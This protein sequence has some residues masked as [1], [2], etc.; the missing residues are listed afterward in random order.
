MRL[1]LRKCIVNPTQLNTKLNSHLNQVFNCQSPIRHLSYSSCLF[2]R[3]NNLD[4]RNNEKEND[5]IKKFKFSQKQN[6]SQKLREKEYL[7][8]QNNIEVNHI[9]VIGSKYH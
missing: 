8:K 1:L 3:N 5:F 4:K 9:L 2:Q 7:G 6:L